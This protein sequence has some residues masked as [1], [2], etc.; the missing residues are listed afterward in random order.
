MAKSYASDAGVRCAQFAIQVHAGIGM[1]WEHDL[2][3]FLKRAQWNAHV[4]NP[5]THARARVAELIGL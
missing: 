1:T 5:T 4:P 2:H 3:F